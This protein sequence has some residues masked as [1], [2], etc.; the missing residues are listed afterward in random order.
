MP[1]DDNNGAPIRQSVHGALAYTI[2]S[3]WHTLASNG[4]APVHLDLST[5]RWPSP[6]SRPPSTFRAMESSFG[7]DGRLVLAADGRELP[8]AGNSIVS[9]QELCAR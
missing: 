5:A 9:T 7:P 1:A 6:A 3:A 2:F 8:F 4:P